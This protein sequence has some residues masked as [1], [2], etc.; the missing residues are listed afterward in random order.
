MYRSTIRN[1]YRNIG[2]KKE[3][4]NINKERKKEDWTSGQN[5]QVDR[6]DRRTVGTVGNNWRM[7]KMTEDNC[8]MGNT[9]SQARILK[10]LRHFYT[11]SVLHT[12]SLYSMLKIKLLKVTNDFNITFD[13]NSPKFHCHA[14]FG[15]QNQ[16]YRKFCL[17][18]RLN[19][20]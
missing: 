9:E 12:L 11:V 2:R 19:P 10:V 18:I 1:I 16:D 4:K 17:H 5:G 15:E 20:N 3:R 14:N 6:M 7:N 13:L 8:R